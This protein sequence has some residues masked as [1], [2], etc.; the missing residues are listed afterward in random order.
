M[1]NRKYHMKIR[2]IDDFGTTF[3]NPD[4]F[5]DSLAVGTVA[6]TA[7]IIMEFGMT[8]FCTLTDVAAKSARFTVHDSP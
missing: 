8:A 6:V 7:G 3:I 4:F 5:E 1:R 2:S